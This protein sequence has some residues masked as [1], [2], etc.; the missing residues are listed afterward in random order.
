MATEL[1]ISSSR[2]TETVLRVSRNQFREW[3]RRRNRRQ[4]IPIMHKLVAVMAG[5]AAE[6]IQYPALAREELIRLSKSDEEKARDFVR[7]LYGGHLSDGEVTAYVDAAEAEATQILRS[8]WPAAV[9]LAEALQSRVL[10][11]GLDGD[12]AMTIM[13]DAQ[14]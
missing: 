4:S 8:G 13:D 7:H 11:C 12:E 1:R 9:A 10:A 2:W 3:A 14:L 6:A 5:R